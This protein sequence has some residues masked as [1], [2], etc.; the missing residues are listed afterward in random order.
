MAM[1]TL[2][3]RVTAGPIATVGRNRRDELKRHLGLSK[4]ERLVLV[5]MGGI[6]SRLPV[7][8]W[9]RIDGVRWLVQKSWNAV[10]P[11]CIVLETLP[12]DFCDLL[13]SVDTLLC[14]PGYGSFVEAAYSGTPVLYVDRPDWPESPALIEWLRQFGTSIEVSRAQLE[15]GDFSNELSSLWTAPKPAPPSTDGAEQIAG[16]LIRALSLKGD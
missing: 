14:K 9:P 5:S 11:D 8:N 1:D 2:N 4:D 10:H 15:S 13:A 16:W 3:N 6:A 12:L 7:E